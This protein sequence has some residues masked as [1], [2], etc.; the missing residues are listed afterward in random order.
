VRRPLRPP[1][2]PGVITTATLPPE[3]APEP[4]PEPEPELEPEPE[5]YPNEF[6]LGL[7]LGQ[8]SDYT[9]LAI[10]EQTFV[11][12]PDSPQEK[13][14]HYGARFLKRWQLGTSYADIIEDLR[15]IIDR[16]PLDMPDLVPDQTGVGQVVIQMLRQANLGAHLR[17]VLITAG[18]QV[19]RGDDDA[20][21]VP[22]KELASTLQV[23]LQQRRLKI[24]PLPERDL[25]Q[26]ELLAFRVKVTVAGHETF[27][28]WRERD[29][30]DLVLAVALAA[31]AG[32]R[33]PGIF[34]KADLRRMRGKRPGR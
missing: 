14:G 3:P 27:E 24:A 32:E 8:S 25:L 9:A 7:D 23:L 6:F 33:G 5:P 19:L 11:P 12:R 20:M 21:H 34:G 30:D 13:E 26:K 15:G 2:R 1:A 10:L 29:H 22:K 18:H 17:P 28:A 4:E 31:W 16:L